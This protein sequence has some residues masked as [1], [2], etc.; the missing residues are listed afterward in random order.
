M[1][2]TLQTFFIVC[3]LVFLASFVD[4]VAGGGGLI[5]LPA[6]L[7]AG[8][9][10]HNSIATNKLSSCV[11]TLISTIRFCKHKYTDLFTAIPS[12]AA[13]LIGSALGAHLTMRV[14]AI[15]LQYVLIIILPVASF[16]V[17]KKDAFA[18]TAVS[19]LSRAQVCI[20]AVLISFFIGGYDGFYGPGTGTF[21]LLLYT[22]ICKMDIKTAS[23]NT[24]L[25]NFSSNLAALITF[26]INGQ[27]IIVLGLVA[28][29]FSI[30]GHY[31][32]SSLVMKKGSS[33]VRPIMLVVLAIL[34]VKCT[35]EIL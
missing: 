20:L 25:V 21:L 29:I 5:S 22:N 3:P 35:M 34:F 23:G 10:I 1:T 27:I 28:G 32:G 17:I 6:Y 4:A 24:K 16:F 13:A 8:V 19:Q 31:A 14:S 9:P 30:A 2:L 33:I 12:I 11:G 18:E 15:S 7:L 26:I